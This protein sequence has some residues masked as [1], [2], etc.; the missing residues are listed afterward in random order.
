MY[1]MSRGMRQDPEHKREHLS[2]QDF[3]LQQIQQ[4]EVLHRNDERASATYIVL[5]MLF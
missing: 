1:G 5:P 3:K 4:E 2:V